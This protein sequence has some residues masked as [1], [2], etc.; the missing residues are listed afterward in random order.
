MILAANAFALA[1]AWWRH[2]PVEL[3]LVSY[4]LQSAI[5]AWYGHRRIAAV[6][7]FVWGK[8]QYDLDAP[9]DEHASDP[10]WA[11]SRARGEIVKRDVMKSAIGIALFYHGAVFVML[12]ILLQARG[13]RVTLLDL[14]GIAAAAAAFLYTHSTSF[15]RNLE[16]DRSGSPRIRKLMFLSLQRVL[17]MHLIMVFGL[18]L[19]YGGAMFVFGA[20]KTIADVA[21]HRVER[22][23]LA[24]RG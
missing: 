18:Q 9:G 1:I 17:P 13:P 2:W 12:V 4:W 24:G 10:E 15:H 21:M 23:V 20:F 22:G 7:R 14:L 5:I 3:L 8:T 6:R 19:G 16:S 11:G